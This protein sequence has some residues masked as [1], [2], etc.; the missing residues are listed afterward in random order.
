[1]IKN[2]NIFINMKNILKQKDMSPI[3]FQPKPKHYIPIYQIFLNHTTILLFAPELMPKL[4][5]PFK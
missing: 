4:D 2:Q 5:I 1:M 3:K